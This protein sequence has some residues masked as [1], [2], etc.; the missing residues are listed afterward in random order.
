MVWDFKEPEASGPVEPGRNPS[1]VDNH[2]VFSRD[3][4]SIW[5]N[6]MRDGLAQLVRIDIP[7]EI[8]KP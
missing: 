6:R 4:R 8:L 5:L 3:G 7:E 1:H 2:P